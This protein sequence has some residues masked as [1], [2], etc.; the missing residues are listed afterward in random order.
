MR[1]EH[2]ARH[3]REQATLDAG[4]FFMREQPQRHRFFEHKCLEFVSDTVD[5]QP[6]RRFIGHGGQRCNNLRLNLTVS[7][8][9]G[10]HAPRRKSRTIRVS[11]SRIDVMTND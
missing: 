7:F 3:Q 10:D 8:G 2:G 6:T 5:D 9:G 1:I 4:I 11:H